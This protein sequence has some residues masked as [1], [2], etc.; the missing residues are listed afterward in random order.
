MRERER[1][2][3]RGKKLGLDQF[4]R[5]SLV[6]PLIVQTDRPLRCIFARIADMA[7]CLV[8]PK[9]MHVHKLSLVNRKPIQSPGYDL[10]EITVAIWE[11]NQARS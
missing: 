7:T 2:G 9:V 8:R 11:T 3:A 6:A 10:P 4:A 5:A 1:G